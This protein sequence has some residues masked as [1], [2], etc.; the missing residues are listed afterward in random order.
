MA[1][2][3]DRRGNGEY[4]DARRRVRAM[5][6]DG[7]IAEF[8]SQCGDTADVFTII[9]LCE[10]GD[11]QWTPSWQCFQRLID[12]GGLSTVYKTRLFSACIRSVLPDMSAEDFVAVLMWAPDIRVRQGFG[13]LVFP[14]NADPLLR[15]FKVRVFTAFTNFRIRAYYFQSETCSHYI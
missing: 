15:D 4:L 1:R 7:S 11:V 13:G 8:L 6:A 12:E 10:N 2:F 14:H 9:A 5:V 3:R